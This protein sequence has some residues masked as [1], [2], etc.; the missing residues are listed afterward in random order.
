MLFK[1]KSCFSSKWTRKL[2]RFKKQTKWKPS[3]EGHLHLAHKHSAFELPQTSDCSTDCKNFACPWDIDGVHFT[4]GIDLFIPSVPMPRGRNHV[5][6][7]GVPSP[8]PQQRRQR[9]W[10]PDAQPCILPTA[11]LG[12]C[13]FL[14]LAHPTEGFPCNANVL[15]DLALKYFPKT[16]S[17]PGSCCQALSQP[18]LWLRAG[19]FCSGLPFCHFFVAA[20][21]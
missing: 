3:V 2:G 18:V 9:A 17:P 8:A 14:V 10:G 16:R 20:R 12:L 13:R 4:I 7:G 11:P 6:S 21:D 1:K 15:T 5:T 19:A